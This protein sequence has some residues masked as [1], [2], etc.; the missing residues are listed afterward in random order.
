MMITE[1]PFGC[2]S[3]PGEKMTEYKIAN[4]SMFEH[5]IT[6]SSIRSLHLISERLDV[7]NIYKNN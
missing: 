4:M 5:L 7:F 2:E 1:I 6:N 3:T